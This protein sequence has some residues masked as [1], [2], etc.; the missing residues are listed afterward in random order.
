MDKNIRTLK[1]WR[2]KSKDTDSGRKTWP[3]QTY[4]HLSFWWL[5][6]SET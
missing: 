2:E 3:A 5:H 6:S 1:E 4:K